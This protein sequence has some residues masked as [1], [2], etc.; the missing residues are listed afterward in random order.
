MHSWLAQWSWNAALL[1]V[2]VTKN[3]QQRDRLRVPNLQKDGS[4][5]RI[6]TFQQGNGVAQRHAMGN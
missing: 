1:A 5:G 6:V 2:R 4:V 3:F